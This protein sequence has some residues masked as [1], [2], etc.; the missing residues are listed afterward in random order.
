MSAF[1]RD[2]VADLD[3]VFRFRSAASRLVVTPQYCVAWGRQMESM[4]LAVPPATVAAYPARVQ[5]LLGYAIHP[6][7]M[8]HV[9]GMH[10]AR[11][12]PPA[13]AA[14]S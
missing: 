4:L 11:T 13:G 6:P 1:L 3:I 7:F 10:P 5:Q 14:P 9:D 2:R 8:G 12:L